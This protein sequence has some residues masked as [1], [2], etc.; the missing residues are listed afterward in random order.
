MKIARVDLAYLAGVIDSDGYIGVKRSTYAM[1]VRGDAGFPM[2]SERICVK[3]VEPHATEMLHAFFGGTLGV[4]KASAAKGRSLHYWQVTDRNAFAC[5]K[6]LLP[7]L[8]I[9]RGQTENLVE[10]RKI[11]ER[12]KKVRV[13]K[14][15]GHVGGAP[16][17][18]EITEAMERLYL[19]G[20][21]MNRVGI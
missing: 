16:R 18:A 2:Y 12:S 11:K 10:L 3:Q 15:R 8:R 20:K 5:A 21:A 14:G 13:A 17:P 9:K 6:S 1:R 4:T 7:F 19:A